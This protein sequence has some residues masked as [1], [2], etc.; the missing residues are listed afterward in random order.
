MYKWYFPFFMQILTPSLLPHSPSHT[1][2]QITDA[3]MNRLTI[4]TL[5]QDMDRWIEKRDQ[6]SCRADELRYH[7][8]Q[9]LKESSP[10]CVCVCVCVCVS[11]WVSEWSGVEWSGVEWSEWESE[12]VSEWVSGVEWSGVSERVSEWVSECINAKAVIYYRG[13][14]SK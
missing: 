2:P 12:W 3:I 11:E 14:R 9:P 4:S 8:K 10:V 7:R 5:S 1:L 13:L 6:L